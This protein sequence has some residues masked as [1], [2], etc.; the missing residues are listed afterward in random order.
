MPSEPRHLPLLGRA[1]I[2]QNVDLAGQDHIG[3]VALVALAEQGFAR[4]EPDAL[5]AEGQQ[6]QVRGA[7]VLEDRHLGQ[8]SRFRADR[9]RGFRCLLCLFFG[10]DRLDPLLLVLDDPLVDA[11]VA[12]HQNLVEVG[13]VRR[14]A[15]DPDDGRF[16]EQLED[17]PPDPVD[18]LAVV[19][20]KRVI[21]DEDDRPF[22]ERPG[23]RQALPRGR[24]QPLTA[25]A[26]VGA[27]T[28]NDDVLEDS[29]LRHDLAQELIDFLLGVRAALVVPP[30]NEVPPDRQHR[31]EVVG[32][33][34]GD[35][36]FQVI[37]QFL[38]EQLPRRDDLLLKRL[39]DMAEA[40][41]LDADPGSEPDQLRA[42]FLG[43]AVDL[44][45]CARQDRGEPVERCVVDK[46]ELLHEAR[47]GFRVSENVDQLLGDL[48]A[49][50]LELRLQTGFAQDFA[51]V[52]MGAELVR[53]QALVHRLPEQQIGSDRRADVVGLKVIATDQL[54]QRGVRVES[55]SDRLPRLEQLV[56]EIRRHGLVD[57]DIQPVLKHDIV[58]F[59]GPDHLEPPVLQLLEAGDAGDGQ[60]GPVLFPVEGAV[61][62]RFGLGNVIGARLAGHHVLQAEDRIVADRTLENVGIGPGVADLP[63][64]RGGRQGR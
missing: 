55:R 60:I 48:E 13:H 51:D 38:V 24:R 4:L 25:D 42:V 3:A 6:F 15:G 32:I 36:V 41:P 21:H 57:P 49:D 29:L 5:R 39:V 61:S 20:R 34:N 53:L 16:G 14:L 62:G 23:E 10:R 47:F 40:M 58:E 37:G 28:G 33:V 12:Q 27:H 44:A 52:G 2:E 18:R 50:L 1:I 8:R 35:R 64:E 45:L 19:R 31:V 63:A 7:D 11:A 26:D 54:L 43:R 46:A 59:D 56:R 9:S 22:D 17:V 30:H